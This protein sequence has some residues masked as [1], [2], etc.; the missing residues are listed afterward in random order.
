VAEAAKQITD[1]GPEE[2]AE[3]ERIE[4]ELD[5]FIEKRA[6]E[7]KD[8]QS[9]EEV[10]QKSA[11]EHH[12]KRQNRVAQEWYFYHDRLIKNHQDTLGSLV[13]YHQK[14][15]AHYAQ[16]LGISETTSVEEKG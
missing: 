10:W 8:A 4:S 7:A 11:K 2:L 9:A 12:E 15:R 1:L 6:R 5:T 14:E 13:L 16:V 3:V